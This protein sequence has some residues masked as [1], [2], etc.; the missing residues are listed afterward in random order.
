MKLVAPEAYQPGLHRQYQRVAARLRLL[1]PC[2]TVEH[3]GSSSVPGVVSKA[4]LDVC[5]IVCVS[6]LEDVVQ[7]LKRNGYTEKTNTLRTGELCML[8]SDSPNDGHAVQVVASGSQF[9]SFFV[10]FRNLL[11]ASPELVAQYNQVK[12]EAA[13]RGSEHYREAKSRFI[14]TALAAQR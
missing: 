14:A 6:Q 4:D 12:T 10:A 2:A 13:K 11:L 7:T 5:L 1:V 3:I 8:V 9:E